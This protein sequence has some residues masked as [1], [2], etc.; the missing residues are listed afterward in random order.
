MDLS[1]LPAVVAIV[2]KHGCPAC[3]EFLPRA[4]AIAERWRGCVPTAFFDAERNDG[5]ANN[6]QVQYTPTVFALRHGTPVRRL[7]GS[8]SDDDVE[9]AYL[10]AARE[11]RP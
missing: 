11:C 2:H 7:E 4:R 10:D 8:V 6:M 3:E 9:K 5:W 1:E